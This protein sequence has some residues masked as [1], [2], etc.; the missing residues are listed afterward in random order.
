MIYDPLDSMSINQDVKGRF[1]ALLRPLLQLGDDLRNSPSARQ[2]SHLSQKLPLVAQ[3]TSAKSAELTLGQPRARPRWA[4]SYFSLVWFCIL[5]TRFLG[6]KGSLA[7]LKEPQFLL[8]TKPMIVK[9]K[10]LPRIIRKFIK[11]ECR[12]ETLNR[13]IL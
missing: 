5:K 12:I 11:S 1:W 10:F 6:R 13:E 2:P 3:R 9:F 8:I 7:Y 4:T